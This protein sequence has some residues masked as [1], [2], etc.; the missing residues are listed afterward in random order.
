MTEKVK[1]KTKRL[2]AG[3]YYYRGFEIVCVG[4]YSP[5][6]KVCWEAVDEHGGGFAQAFSLRECK[7]WIDSELDGKL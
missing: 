2:G 7:M 5:E 1:H 6:G 4:Y 3:H